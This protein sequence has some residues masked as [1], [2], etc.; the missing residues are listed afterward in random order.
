MNILTILADS[1]IKI[2]P[3]KIGIGDPARIEENILVK[4]LETAYLWGGIICVIIIIVGGYFYVT[5]AGN[6]ANVKRGKDAVMGAV[7]GLIVILF[8]FIITQF[9]LGRF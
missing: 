8:A 5:S 2:D 6:A 1:S 4:V 9:V 3:G 7:I